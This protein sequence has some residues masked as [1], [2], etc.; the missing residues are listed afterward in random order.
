[1]CPQQC[2]LVYQG[3]NVVIVPD[4]CFTRTYLT[5]NVTSPYKILG[6]C[7]SHQCYNHNEEKILHQR[8]LVNVIDTLSRGKIIP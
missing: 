6:K 4:E 2:V 5:T 1:M 8:V 7:Y 3:L